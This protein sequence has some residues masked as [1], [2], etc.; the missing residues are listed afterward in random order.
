V[1]V[2]INEESALSREQRRRAARDEA[3]HALANYWRALEGTL[4]PA[5]IERATSNA[6]IG[7]AEEIIEQAKGR[8]HPEDKLM[9]WFD[10]NNHDSARVMRNMEAFMTKVAPALG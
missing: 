1:L 4:D 9:L 7:D 2:F 3:E 8:F 6:L 10:F 5:K